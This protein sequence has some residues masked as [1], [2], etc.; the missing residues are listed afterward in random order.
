MKAK[1]NGLRKY[2]L[3][4][5]QSLIIPTDYKHL[6]G[7]FDGTQIYSDPRPTELDILS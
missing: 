4:D 5:I 1:A 2:F 6:T 3:C 7:L